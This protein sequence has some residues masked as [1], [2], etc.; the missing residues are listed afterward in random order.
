M[1]RIL[2]DHYAMLGN[3][4]TVDTIQ[5][6]KYHRIM[7]E[8][9]VYGSQS[10]P[11]NYSTNKNSQTDKEMKKR[12]DL[13]F[14]SV[15]RNKSNMDFEHFLQTLVKVAEVKFASLENPNRG[16]KTLIDLHMLPLAARL[17]QK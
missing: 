14:C 15:N 13:I 5:S 17:Q 1:L 12:L 16:L 11:G 8:A 6:Q 3:R 2:F 9:G 7:K 10:G 4:M